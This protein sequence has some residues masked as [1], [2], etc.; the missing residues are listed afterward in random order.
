MTARDL[1]NFRLV[2]QQIAQSQCKTPEQV[3]A[4]L[5]AMQA[6]DYPGALWS[7]SLCLPNATVADIEK[8][9][10][11]RAIIRTW[12]M[13]GTLHFVAAADVR[14]MLELL[15]ARIVARWAVRHAEFGLDTALFAR[16][17]KLLVKALQGGRTVKRGDLLALLERSGISTADFRGHVILWRLAQ[18]R[19][20]CFGPHQGKQPTFALLDEW[21]PKAKSLDRDHAVAEL[22]LRYFTGHGPATLRDFAWWSGLK[23]AEAKAALEM[24]SS[25]LVRETIDDMTYW[26]PPN[27]LALRDVSPTAYLL[28][29]FDEYMIGY[30]ERAAFL[31]ARHP[32]KV[33]P[34]G[35]AV[36]KPTIVM[37]GR[38]AGVWQRAFKRNS[39]V[40]SPLSFTKLK[41]VEAQS[42][43]APAERYGQFHGLPVTLSPR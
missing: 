28:S 33:I 7:I 16:C 42:L 12:P 39:V 26:M 43:S 29:G 22:A 21:T 34:G 37:D 2:N 23:A 19:V 30:T 6:Q 4:L 15:A 20:I 18:E 40:I 5:G 32:G 31:E 3:V 14:W 36:F 13:R 17:E 38:V 8:A 41:K 11:D 1:V 35:N 10:S 25:K 27:T 24:V 9:V